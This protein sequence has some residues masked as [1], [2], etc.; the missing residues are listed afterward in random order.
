MAIE[1]PQSTHSAREGRTKGT[2]IALINLFLSVYLLL[3]IFAAWV[4]IPTAGTVC[5]VHYK[6]WW[7]SLTDGSAFLLVPAS[8]AFGIVAVRSSRQGY[9]GLLL[10]LGIMNISLGILL[11]LSLVWAQFLY[12]VC[13]L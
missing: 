12:F 4:F 10:S 1:T 9:R 6:P 5:L 13:Q 11:L 7:I 3:S 2:P 8:I